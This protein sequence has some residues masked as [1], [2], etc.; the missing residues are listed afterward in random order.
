MNILQS[1]VLG[2]IQGLTEFLPISSTGHLLIVRE[3][4]GLDIES[5]LSFDVFIQLGT[6]L[7][8][9]FCFWGDLKRIVV[10]LFTEGFSSRSRKLLLAL[11][12]GTIPAVLL[13]YFW[14]DALEEIVRRPDYV[15][16]ALI[17]GSIIF[18]F[19]DQIPKGDE[20][21]VG[22][23][24]GLFIGVFQMFALVPGVSHS[25]ITISGGLF[26]GLSREEAIR[27]SFLLSIPIMLGAGARTLIGP[28]AISLTDPYVWVG[29][30]AAFISGLWAVKFLVRY[31][32]KHSFTPFIIYRLLL[33]A[34]ILYFL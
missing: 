23:I 1:I 33:A 22:P 10:D 31:L 14:G 26:F 7:A 8:V 11:I 6:L 12:L 9:I 3:L 16:Y 20:G 5:S 19:A 15:A 21:G 2:L 13:G 28:N 30:V 4:L 27:F 29:F 32:S 34:A 24:K 25:G 17:A 18:F